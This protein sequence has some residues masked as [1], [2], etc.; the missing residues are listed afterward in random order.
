MDSATTQPSVYGNVLSEK[1]AWEVG[2]VLFIN[3]IWKIFSYR[4]R[5]KFFPYFTLFTKINFMLDFM[6]LMYV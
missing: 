6:E 2:K 1:V 4:K 3:S 5:M